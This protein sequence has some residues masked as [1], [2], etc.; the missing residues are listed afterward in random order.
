M[1]QMEARSEEA[2]NHRVRLEA[3]QDENTRL[4]TNIANEMRDSMTRLVP[5]AD[6]TAN[7]N[8]ENGAPLVP[9]GGNE[10]AQHQPVDQRSTPGPMIQA[11][12]NTEQDKENQIAGGG[13][14]ASETRASAQNKRPLIQNS[15][16]GP[17]AAAKRAKTAQE[18]A[19]AAAGPLLPSAGAGLLASFQL[20]PPVERQPGAPSA[21]GAGTGPAPFGDD[22]DRGD[23]WAWEFL[24]FLKRMDCTSDKDMLRLK[25]YVKGRQ[26]CE[27]PLCTDSPTR[28]AKFCYF[29]KVGGRLSTTLRY[30][31]S[32]RPAQ[33]RASEEEVENLDIFETCLERRRSAAAA[34]A[35]SAHSNNDKKNNH[36]PPRY[37]VP[38]GEV[39]RACRSAAALG[40][41][42]VASTN[43]FVFMDVTRPSK[44]LWL[45]YRY[46]R[47]PLAGEEGGLW[48]SIAF[49]N[50]QREPVFQSDG[51]AFDT[52]CLLDDV[53]EWRGP[54][55]EMV[56]D[57]GRFAAALPR[58]VRSLILRPVLNTP[59]LY[60]LREDMKQ[61]WEGPVGE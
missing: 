45:I 29:L 33:P 51:K 17:S 9:D 32:N 20:R 23:Q 14:V 4:L 13:E 19:A 37:L 53:R 11:R 34:A 28:R 52:A 35:N 7:A 57:S 50:P 15:E 58:G 24:S 25:K 47:P 40:L 56:V 21:P 36:L 12:E 31:P 26:S 46:E 2:E 30:N 55:D 16:A 44:S 42:E 54:A 6:L 61:G 41:E 10:R 43:F 22:E 8:R 27:F 60:R 1:Q 18:N 48:R 59:I 49:A 39:Y 5:P 3:K 38:L